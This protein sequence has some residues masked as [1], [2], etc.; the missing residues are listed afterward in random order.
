[1][2]LQNL[3]T[4]RQ[5]T[6]SVVTQRIQETLDK[7]YE[8]IEFGDRL[9]RDASPAQVSVFKRLLEARLRAISATV[10]EP[11]LAMVSLFFTFLI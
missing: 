8:A 6:L 11:S 1:M 3:Y 5:L 2:E 7:M 9:I 4:T 10:P